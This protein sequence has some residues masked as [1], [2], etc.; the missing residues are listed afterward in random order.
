MDLLEIAENE[1]V[2]REA[3]AARLH[4]I[5]D[6]LA[7]NNEVEFERADKRITVHVPDRLNLKV[8]VEVADDGCEIEIELTW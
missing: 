8:E 2:S 1:L 7:R 4:A 6:V 3:A 5:A